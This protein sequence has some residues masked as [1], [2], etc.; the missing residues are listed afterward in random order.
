MTGGSDR[1]VRLGSFSL[2]MKITDPPR[3]T[4]PKKANF[5]GLY[6]TCG[7]SS[8]FGSMWLLAP[9]TQVS[10]SGLTVATT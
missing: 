8:T 7:L 9:P 4:P 2:R 6:L 1:S 3:E 10:P 5:V